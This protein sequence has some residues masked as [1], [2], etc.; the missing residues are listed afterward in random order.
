MSTTLSLTKQDIESL[1]GY[2]RKTHKEYSAPC[3]FCGE[4]DDRFLFWPKTGNYY[5]RQCGATGFV[6]SSN[7]PA[8]KLNVKSKPHRQTPQ[9]T[10]YAVNT[11]RNA[12]PL[13]D[14]YHANLTPILRQHWYKYGLTNETIDAR[15]LGYTSHCPT[16][17]PCASLTIPIFYKGVL[18]NIRHRLINPP[19]EKGKYRPQVAGIPALM[20]NADLLSERPDWIMLVEGEVKAMVLCQNGIPAVGIPGASSFRQEWVMMFKDI[21]TYVMFDPG[22][23]HQTIRV[24]KLLCNA[25]GLPPPCVNGQYCKPDDFFS[26]YHKTAQDF[27]RHLEGNL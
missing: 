12:G 10:Q 20:Y 21:Q 17:R 7:A 3:P 26:V 5:C 11:I 2:R 27:L 8:K 15:L 9:L 23:E 4:G 24:I 16:W 22:A 13:A 25:R 18:L 14:Q 6:I 1:P 19:E